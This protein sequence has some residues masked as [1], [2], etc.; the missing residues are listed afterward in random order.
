MNWISAALPAMTFKQS[1]PTDAFTRWHQIKW[2]TEKFKVFAKFEVCA[3]SS[4]E[5]LAQKMQT[6]LPTKILLPIVNWKW[7]AEEE[8]GVV[9]I[10]EI[11]SSRFEES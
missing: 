1:L 4:S 5:I 9:G 2:D 10:G 8:T 7:S 11:S 6:L 3:P